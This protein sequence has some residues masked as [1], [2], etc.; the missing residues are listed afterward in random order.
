MKQQRERRIPVV[1]SLKGQRRQISRSSH[2]YDR[3]S[4]REESSSEGESLVAVVQ[5]RR[6][7]KQSDIEMLKGIGDSQLTTV[8]TLE[9]GT[10]DKTVALER[11][12][13][14]GYTLLPI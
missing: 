3:V 5:V 4:E 9:S 2:D 6:Q 11:S 8:R 10:L 12:R 1:I 7:L 13:K 14:Q